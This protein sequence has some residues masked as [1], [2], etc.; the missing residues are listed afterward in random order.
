MLFLAARYH[1]GKITEQ[2][3]NTE[4]YKIHLINLTKSMLIL[5][6]R[7]MTL[8][9]Q[10]TE[11]VIRGRT[12]LKLWREAAESLCCRFCH[13]RW[14]STAGMSGM[15]ACWHSMPRWHPWNTSSCHLSGGS[16]EATPVLASARWSCIGASLFVSLL[17]TFICIT[18]PKC[19]RGPET[20][21]YNWIVSLMKFTDNPV[22][23]EQGNGFS[24]STGGKT[25]SLRLGLT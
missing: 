7:C 21:K 5:G 9:C 1:L 3:N 10:L 13:V 6:E 4:V 24:P 11:S 16:R 22:E 17:V 19:I 12:E 20:Y 23:Q 25:H 8:Y 14:V 15:L 18:Y 2:K